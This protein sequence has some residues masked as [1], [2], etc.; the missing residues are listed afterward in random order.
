V[1]GLF[2]GIDGGGSKT[3]AVVGNS[4][5]QVL[6]QG[7]GGPANYHNVGIETALASIKQS[8]DHAL[9]QAGAPVGD[10]DRVVL[11]LAGAD[12]PSDFDILTEACHRLF[13]GIPFEVTNDTWI[14][15]RAGSRSGW[16]AV[17]ICGAS[18]NAAA[19]APDGRRA[20]LRGLAYEM[21][22]KGGARDI[23]R[24]ALYH[25]FRSE[26]GVGPRTML[27]DAVLE[28]TEHRDYTS[29]ASTL[30]ELKGE[31]TPT[32]LQLCPLV[33][34]LAVAGDEVCQEIL[35][36]TGRAQGQALAGL[37]RRLRIETMSFEVVLSGSVY[38]LG[39]SPLLIDEFATTLHRTAP[40]AK[41]ALQSRQPAVGAYLLALEGTDQ[42]PGKREIE[43]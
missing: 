1:P 42:R 43:T 2:V 33:S 36:A 29:L 3:L 17:S 35:I 41:I 23:A 8:L 11:G 40:L 20:V 4:G 10:I 28:V 31:I 21:G 5:G 39:T 14:A 34:D 9:N 6:G 18:T 12:L 38:Q 16:G 24:D 7:Q 32:M 19:L 13:P 27:E 22:N 26:E 15:L 30:L 25:A 37:V